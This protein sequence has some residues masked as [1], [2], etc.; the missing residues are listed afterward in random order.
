M[1]SAASRCT[2][3]AR[4]AAARVASSPGAAS[5][6]QQLPR[7]RRR[8]DEEEDHQ[9]SHAPSVRGRPTADRQACCP[10]D[11]VSVPAPASPAVSGLAMLSRDDLGLHAE[12][13]RRRRPRSSG[14]PRDEAADRDA[15]DVL[16]RRRLVDEVPEQ[17]WSA[18]AA[19]PRCRWRRRTRCTAPASPSGRPHWPRYAV[20]PA[21]AKKKMIT[22][23][24]RVSGERGDAAEE[25]PGHA[26]QGAGEDV[27]ER[28]HLDPPGSGRTAAEDQCA[29]EVAGG[30]DREV[31]GGLLHA[32]E[33]RERVPVG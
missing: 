2:G 20:A 15:R 7:D 13:A 33:R 4:R 29:G 16:V 17:Q 10:A 30:E 28:D 3:P 27:G 6:E 26:E 32:E 31:P 18:D 5:R 24:S 1:S 9:G 8:E 22:G 25:E 21:D 19:S 23:P 14:R 11:L 12:P